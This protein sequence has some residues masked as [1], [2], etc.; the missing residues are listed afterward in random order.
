VLADLGE[1]PLGSWGEQPLTEV[2]ARVFELIAAAR[3]EDALEL[4]A[5]SVPE[6]AAPPRLR[7][8]R[9]VARGHLAQRD[10]KFDDARREFETALAID[11]SCR[12]AILALRGRPR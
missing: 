7:A 8:A 6:R 4:I 1:E 12:E 2:A 5:T 3:Y 10:G 9:Y 11:R